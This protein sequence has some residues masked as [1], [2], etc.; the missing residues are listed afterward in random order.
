MKLLAYFIGFILFIN[1]LNSV[2]PKFE[3]N[4]Y[5]APSNYEANAAIFCAEHQELTKQDCSFNGSIY[6]YQGGAIVIA[7]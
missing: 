1:L 5:R 2:I 3:S 4:A 6:K 7:K